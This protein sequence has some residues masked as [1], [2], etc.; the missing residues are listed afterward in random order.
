MLLKPVKCYKKKFQKLLKVCK[1]K[2]RKKT[3]SS[4][5]FLAGKEFAAKAV[6]VGQEYGKEALEKTEKYAEQVYEAGKDKAEGL[7]K[8]AKK[9]LDL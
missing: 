1:L 2:S 3:N 5:L 8:D 4:L 6:E 9:R 7:Y